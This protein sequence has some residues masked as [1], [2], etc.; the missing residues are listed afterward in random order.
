MTDELTYEAFTNNMRSKFQVTVDP[1]RTVELKLTEVSERKLCPGQEQF[2]ITFQGPGDVFLGQGM[3][4][5]THEV[6]GAFDLFV[7]PIRQ[8]ADGIY[9][10]A[11]FNRFR[12]ENR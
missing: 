1:D 4:L 7:V 12:E 5:F 2:T 10:E 3:R 11:V 9:Y 8:D 6:M